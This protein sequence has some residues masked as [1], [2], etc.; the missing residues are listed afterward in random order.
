M[1]PTRSAVRSGVAESSESW[2]KVRRRVDSADRVVGWLGRILRVALPG[3]AI[4]VRVP[5]AG[6]PAIFASRCVSGGSLDESIVQ[7]ARAELL[8]RGETAALIQSGV[9][10]RVGLARSR[11]M[12]SLL[13]AADLAGVIVAQRELGFVDRDL[14][15][16][17]ATGEL[18]SWSLEHGLLRID[19]EESAQSEILARSVLLLSHDLVK[20]VTCLRA[21]I[22]SLGGERVGT[23]RD[24]VA[25]KTIEELAVAVVHPLRTLVRTAVNFDE[26]AFAKPA[27]LGK[28]LSRAIRRVEKLRRCRMI[29]LDLAD[30]TG[31]LEVPRIVGAIVENL[32]DNAVVACRDDAQV[33]IGAGVRGGRI[34]V[35]VSNEGP[36]A[37]A[38]VPSTLRRLP[39]SGEDAG[40]GLGV[41]LVHSK[42]LTLAFGGRLRLLPRGRGGMDAILDLPLAGRVS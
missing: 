21:A 28:V 33:G 19:L 16:L 22:G 2:R 32:L 39:G 14:D 1:A 41:G 4:A 8:R 6:D 18:A 15:L 3:A 10:G 24:D 38:A 36:G 12:A 7:G 11:L 5:V 26:C 37:V 31:S 40:R 30:G 29:D 25:L 35:R 13:P 34:S 9:L 17:A 27:T 42:A 23:S 20:N